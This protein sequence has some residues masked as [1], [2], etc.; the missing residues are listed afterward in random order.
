MRGRGP[1]VLAAGAI[2]VA[3]IYLLVSGTVQ[4]ARY[5]VGVS[6]L[7]AMGSEAQSRSLT[8]SGAVVGE[9]IVYDPEIPLVTFTVADIPMDPRAV[10]A[11]GG[12]EAVCAAAVVDPGR[13]RLQIVFEGPK[14]DM[15]RHEAQ[16][17][18]RGRLGEDGRLY[19]D[20]I[21]LRCPSRYQEA[22]SDA[23]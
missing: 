12:L 15:L 19:A 9:T 22:S 16:A 10:R 18:V 7:L 1:Y 21:L 5:Y 6:E 4:S 8:V 23:R 11:A 20:E 17:I 14:Q 2:V 3:A 13:D